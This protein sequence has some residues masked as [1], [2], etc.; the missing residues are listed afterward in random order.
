MLHHY[1]VLPMVAL[2]TRKI[3]LLQLFLA[4]I[5][6]IFVGKI[7]TL[8]KT[9]QLTKPFVTNVKRKVILQ[10]FVSEKRVQTQLL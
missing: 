10:K 1:T 6:V 9:I 3:I 7:G 5:I 4:R 2:K 8:K